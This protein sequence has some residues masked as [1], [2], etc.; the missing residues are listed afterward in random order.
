MTYHYYFEESHNRYYD[1]MPECS[2]CGRKTRSTH[3]HT[4]EHNE[5][6][7]R[8]GAPARQLNC[9]ECEAPPKC[10]ARIGIGVC[11]LGDD[12]IYDEGHPGPHSYYPGNMTS[13]NKHPDGCP[14]KMSG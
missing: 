8:R 2:K 3:H 12:C 10:H 6:L 4:D 7:K 14:D 1:A 9:D 5:K 11:T 13:C